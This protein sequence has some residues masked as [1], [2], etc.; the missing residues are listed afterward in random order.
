VGAGVVVVRVNPTKLIETVRQSRG[1]SSV[2]LLAS[3]PKRRVTLAHLVAFAA[4]GL[5]MAIDT[6]G[7]APAS[8]FVGLVIVSGFALLHVVS[9]GKALAPSTLALDAV[10]TAVVV[11]GTGAPA[12]PL[13][14]L[15]AAG[16]WW[17]AHVPRRQTGLLH[18]AAFGSAAV[19][20][21]A[22][23]PGGCET[24]GNQNEPGGHVQSPVYNLVPRG[25]RIN[26]PQV[27]LSA[28]CPPGLNQFLGPAVTYTLSRNGTIVLQTTFIAS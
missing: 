15:G 6:R 2:R 1:R 13:F 5:V 7:T 19:T 12:S 16:V 8:L 10:G 25:G 22:I 18:A 11:G 28:N 3:E 24:R 26:T 17:A 14:L 23:T 20:F 21:V 4:I 9:A 27:T